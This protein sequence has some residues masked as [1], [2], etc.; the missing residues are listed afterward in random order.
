VHATALLNRKRRRSPQSAECLDPEQRPSPTDY[1]DQ[2]VDFCLGQCAGPALDD[3]YLHDTFLT[4]QNGRGMTT[5]VDLLG[6]LCTHLAEF[7]L[8]TIALMHVAA[9]VPAPQMTVQLA[10]H[11]PPQIARALLA[12]ADVTTEAWRVP[13]VTTLGRAT[14]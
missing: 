13:A 5:T 2:L 11:Q 7:E 9:S 14:A 10:C 8:L 1:I 3:S 4:H 6:E 12:R